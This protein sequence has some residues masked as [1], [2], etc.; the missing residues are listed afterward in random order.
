MPS[1]VFSV[2]NPLAL[3]GWVLLVGFPR[4]PWAIL[5][6]GRVLPMLLAG[7]Y[8]AI[9]LSCWWHAPGGFSSLVAV[10]ELFSNEWLLLAGWVHYLAFDLLIGS[11]LVLDARQRE[12]PHLWLVPVLF[13]TF[14][15]GPAGWLAYQMLGLASR[16]RKVAQSK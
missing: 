9:I 12:I 13:L 11:W 1:Q 14:M 10:A 15:F 7:I 16:R 3:V 5:L 8:V 6:A 2:V 4:R